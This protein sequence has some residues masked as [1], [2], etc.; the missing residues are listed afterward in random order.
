MNPR[1]RQLRGKVVIGAVV[2]RHDLLRPPLQTVLAH[3]NR[4]SLSWLQILRK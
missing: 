4:P 3:D 2:S 1:S